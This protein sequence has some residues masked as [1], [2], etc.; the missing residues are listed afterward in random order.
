MLLLWLIVDVV[1]VHAAVG[2]CLWSVACLSG[3][4][5]DS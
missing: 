1:F 2:H 5:L 4:S 3:I